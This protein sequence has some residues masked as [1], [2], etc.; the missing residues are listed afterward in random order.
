MKNNRIKNSNI[1]FF[2]ALLIA[3]PV[4]KIMSNDYQPTYN[5]TYAGRRSIHKV[6]PLEYNETSELTDFFNDTLSYR[7]TEAVN[8][9]SF[10]HT[11]KGIWYK[12]NDRLAKIAEPSEE[13]YKQAKNIVK[14]DWEEEIKK[15]PAKSQKIHKSK[16]YKEKIKKKNIKTKQEEDIL[17]PIVLDIYIES[18]KMS[19]ISPKMDDDLNELPD[20]RELEKYSD[21]LL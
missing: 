5:Y 21:M 16:N 1:V 7:T 20:D 19:R 13:S 18:R 4:Y 10:I 11:P 2:L 6:D 15:K 14:I 8:G 3:L 17:E 9:N 12:K